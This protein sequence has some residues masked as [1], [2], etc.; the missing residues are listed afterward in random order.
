MED[1]INCFGDKRKQIL[2][3]DNIIYPLLYLGLLPNQSKIGCCGKLTTNYYIFNAE[4][5][6]TKKENLFY[7]GKHCAEEILKLI[8]KPKLG[9]F[10]PLSI[11]SHKEQNN[12]K[13]SSNIDNNL[14]PINKELINAI[15]IISIA[16]S[17]IPPS[18]ILKIIEFTLK[19][20]NLINYNGIVWVNNSV[21][22]D[23][24]NRTLTEIVQDL[25]NENPDLRNFTFDN[26]KKEMSLKFP[27]E[28]NRY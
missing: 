4:N 19:N 3:E 5:K 20:P 15:K 1:S 17:S 24:K 27:K 12:N 23:Y 18:S 8:G 9:L 11:V 14:V 7:A 22:K 13:K 2:V 6:K 25:K 21:S 26:L 16:W 10:N 28:I